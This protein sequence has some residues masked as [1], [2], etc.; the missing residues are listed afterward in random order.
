MANITHSKAYPT[1][2]SD[3]ATVEFIVRET[4]SYSIN[5]YDAQGM[6]VKQLQ[7]GTARAGEMTRVEVNGRDLKEGMYF[8]RLVGSSGSKT[9]KLIL[10]R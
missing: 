4:E 5:L 7:S 3:Q 8:A 9:F 10:K 2:F 1:A 6:L